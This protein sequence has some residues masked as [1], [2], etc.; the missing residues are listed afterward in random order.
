VDIDNV[1]LDDPKVYEMLRLGNSI[2]IFQLEATRCA[3]SCDAC[4]DRLR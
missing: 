1:A 2:G 4:A 3:N